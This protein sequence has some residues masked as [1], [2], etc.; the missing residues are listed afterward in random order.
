MRDRKMN[1]ERRKTTNEKNADLLIF[2]FYSLSD[3]LSSKSPRCY[4]ADESLYE[5]TFSAEEAIVLARKALASQGI[6]LGNLSVEE[7]ATLGMEEESKKPLWSVSFFVPLK[8]SSAYDLRV[9]VFLDGEDG[10]L[11][12]IIQ[13]FNI[14]LLTFWEKQKGP[15]YSWTLEER[16]LFSEI[17]TS[18]SSPYIEVVPVAEDLSQEE[19]LTIA[20]KAILS[21]CEVTEEELDS[22]EVSY[23]LSTGVVWPEPT[24]KN[25]DSRYW[26]LVFTFM[27]DSQERD[28]RFQVDIDARNSENIMVEDRIL[29][30]K[31]IG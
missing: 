1:F 16:A 12:H 13:E 31:G 29:A 5:K 21:E 22:Y 26:S 17:T 10:S 8:N 24:E 15:I 3:T 2:A 6:S 14:E 18:S 9:V 19:V 7:K 20:R 25:P 4:L 30:P 27:N 23:S 28:V 11:L